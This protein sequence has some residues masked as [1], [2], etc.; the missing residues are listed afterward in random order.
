[1]ASEK[2]LH[3][4]PVSTEADNF[5]HEAALHEKPLAELPKGRWERSWPVIACGAG[6]FIDGNDFDMYM[7]LDRANQGVGYIN[8]VRPMFTEPM[9]QSALTS[10]I[11]H[12]QR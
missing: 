12:R 6:L 10:D 4:P 11:G 8:G 1:M 3:K 2:D 5:D 9:R 7:A